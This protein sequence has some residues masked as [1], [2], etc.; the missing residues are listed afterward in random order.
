MIVITGG[1]SGGKTTLIEAIKKELGRDV[2]TVPEAASLLYRGGFPRAHSDVEMMRVQAA[3]YHVQEQLEGL[4][5]D[6]NR[7]SKS[8]IVCDRGSLDGLAYWPGGS[9]GRPSFFEFLKT[10]ETAE[11]KRYKWVLHLDTATAET[12]ETTNPLR[13]ET[14]EEAWSLNDRIKRAWANH[15]QRLIVPPNSDFFSKMAL[16]LQLIRGIMS[17]DTYESLKSMLQRTQPLP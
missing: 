9:R 3:I 6:Q 12:Y 7:Q 16:C 2:K 13:I 17:G 4:V 11:V 1:P 8:L 15:P 10:T 5:Q 14:Y